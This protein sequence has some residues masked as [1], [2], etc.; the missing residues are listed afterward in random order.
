MGQIGYMM[1]WLLLMQS[2]EF[3]VESQKFNALYFLFLLYYLALNRVPEGFRI[4]GSSEFLIKT[5]PEK[6]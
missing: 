2:D 3:L 5:L 6:Y 1:S 4:L